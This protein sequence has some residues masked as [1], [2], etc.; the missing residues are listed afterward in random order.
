MHHGL[1]LGSHFRGLR[2]GHDLR[3]VTRDARNARLTTTSELDAGSKQGMDSAL[4]RFTYKSQHTLTCNKVSPKIW[5]LQYMILTRPAQP[6]FQ[7]H[8]ARY[9]FI[10]VLSPFSQI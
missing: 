9:S 1:I 7:F 6:A 3:P 5:Q 2:N 10:Y 4:P 8:R